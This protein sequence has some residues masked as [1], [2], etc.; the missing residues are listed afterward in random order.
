MADKNGDDA[1]HK[2]SLAVWDLASPLVIGR[3]ARVKVGVKCSAGC[4]LTDHEIQI[5][6]Q[7]GRTMAHSSLGAAP[8]PG[9]SGLYW[10]EL[11]FRAPADPGMHTWIVKSVHGTGAC[12]NLTFTAVQPP[13]HNLTIRVREKSTQAPVAEVEVG[14]G[15]YRAASDDQGLATVE[16]PRG[17]YTLNIWKPGYS[18][19]SAALDVTS[20]LTVDVELDV[21]PE[22]AQPYWM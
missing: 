3:P 10:A 6:D 4:Q 21:E 7:T 9:T 17:S 18:H 15:A 11:D 5:H 12:S 8:W 19:F 20:N 16:L 22:P 2:T 14:L 13:D 1:E